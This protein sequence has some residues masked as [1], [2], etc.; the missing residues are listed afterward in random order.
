MLDHQKYKSN[1]HSDLYTSCIKR[2]AED[3][4]NVVEHLS[5]TFINPFVYRMD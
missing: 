5:D 3:A 4:C 1:K 2:D